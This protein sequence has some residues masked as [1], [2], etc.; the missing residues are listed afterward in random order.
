MQYVFLICSSLQPARD[1][2]KN[3]Y[4]MGKR[5]FQFLLLIYMR[6]VM[7]FYAKTMGLS[8]IADVVW[9]YDSERVSMGRVLEVSQT[10]GIDSV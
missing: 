2:I 6:F 4:C 8:F 3:P 5:P 9:H 7:I 1:R 10:D